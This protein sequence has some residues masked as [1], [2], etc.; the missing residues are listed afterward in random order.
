M[1]RRGPAANRGADRMDIG[2]GGSPG[3]RRRS[4]TCKGRGQDQALADLREQNRRDAQLIRN[5]RRVH[6]YGLGATGEL[7][8]E[9]ATQVG[10]L[11]VREEL[12]KK[13]ADKLDHRV[14]RIFRCDVSSLQP[15][16]FG[17]GSWR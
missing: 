9:L 5:L 8:I 7:A 6:G 4:L 14:L 16:R 13:F 1:F 17:G 2:R 10:G 3:T 11:S 12:A 15:L